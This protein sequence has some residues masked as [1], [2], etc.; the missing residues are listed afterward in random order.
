LKLFVEI[1][2]DKSKAAFIKLR[3]IVV[4]ILK[5]CTDNDEDSVRQGAVTVIEGLESEFKES[6]LEVAT[7]K[8]YSTIQ[9]RGMIAEYWTAMAEAVS[10]GFFSITSD[11]EWGF[12]SVSWRHMDRNM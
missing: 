1:P 11:I 7:S 9:A 10:R 6:F 12:H 3:N 4:Q 8:G 2:K 5:Y